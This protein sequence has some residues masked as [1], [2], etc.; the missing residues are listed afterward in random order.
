VTDDRLG[1]RSGASGRE[2][3]EGD[4]RDD[5]LADEAEIEWFP[6][7]QV[8]RDPSGRRAVRGS[9][10]EDEAEPPD[11][12]MAR[13][14][15]VGVVVLV[16]VLG[17][18]AALGFAI[19]GGGGSPG[20]ATLPATTTLPAATT[21]APAPAQ[22]T[23]KPKS[24]PTAS[25]HLVLPAGKLLRAGDTGTAVTRLQRALKAA[26]FDPGAAD[27]SFGPGT[28]QAVVDFQKAK[29][30]SADG[31]VGPTTVAQLNAALG[32]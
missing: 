1:V 25:L 17:A 8:A 7:S 4:P 18:A 21:P 16:V 20:Q 31:V 12:R 2:S 9:R 10:F 27:G 32:G 14:R 29:G 24:N 3:A 15:A 22:S 6:E 5:W 30:L 13:R 23:T 26:G 28:T 11:R 19:F